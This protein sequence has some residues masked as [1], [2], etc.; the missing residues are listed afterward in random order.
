[1]K[2]V[3]LFAP[4]ILAFSEPSSDA[5]TATFYGPYAIASWLLD[6]LRRL[7]LLRHVEIHCVGLGEYDPRLLQ[8]MARAGK[9]RF[10][11]VPAEAKPPK[12]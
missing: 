8:A 1:M 2:E 12:K 7:N 10:G 11:R 9:D 5:K 6:D 3:R 4:S